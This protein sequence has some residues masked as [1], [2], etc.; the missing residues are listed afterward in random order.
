MKTMSQDTKDLLK[1]LRPVF[2]KAFRGSIKDFFSGIVVSVNR[3]LLHYFSIE[4]LKWRFEAIRTGKSFADVVLEH[5][6]VYPVSQV[7]LI[8]R[9][10]GLLLHQVKNEKTEPQDGDMVSSMLTAIVDFVHDSFKVESEYGLDTIKVGEM[11]VLIEQG[12]YAILAGV[13]QG[14]VPDSLREIFQKTL[15]EIHNNYEERLISFKG[16]AE[17]FEETTPFLESCLRLEYIGGEER[18]SPFTAV[19]LLVPLVAVGALAYFTVRQHIRWEKY[20]AVL[21]DAPGIVVIEDGFK[22]LRRHVRGFRD[23]MAEDPDSLLLAAGFSPE[24]VIS[25]WEAYRALDPSITKAWAEYILKPPPTVSLVVDKGSLIAH[26][27][28]TEKWISR[29][30]LLSRNIPGISR[31]VTDRLLDENHDRTLRWNA[32][33]NELT[34]SPGVLIMDKG[35]RAGKPF[36]VGFRDP[37]AINPDTLLAKFGFIAEDVSSQWASFESLDSRLILERAKRV[38]DPPEAVTLSLNDGILFASGSSSHS[39]IEQS[40]ILARTLTGVSQFDTDELADEDLEALNGTIERIESQVFYFL[41]NKTDLWPG[42]EGRFRLLLKDIKI[43]NKLSPKA[44]VNCSIEIRG[45]TGTSTGNDE[46]DK[47]V[48]ESIARQFLDKMRRQRL[49]ADVFIIKG[50]GFSQPD[51]SETERRREG[52]VSF[53]IL[54]TN[55]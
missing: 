9:S 34:H 18:I 2:G 38:L 15:K 16:D 30:V 24:K 50:M 10:T 31:F 47:S 49:D 33:L 12:P 3:F 17:V 41:V 29:A 13:V 8:H 1:T 26:G 4:G 28:A 44:G 5:S 19:V 51:K 48:S 39:W 42:Q 35:I 54:I 40:Y 20:V 21:T 27:T 43:L 36:I 45:H 55:R 11:T 7:F 25:H 22:G 53:K 46:I 37:I 52:S 14:R 32:Y 23:P 6:L